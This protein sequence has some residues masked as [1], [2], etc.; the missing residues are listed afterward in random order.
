MAVSRN[1]KKV[2]MKS[3]K[4]KSYRG[5]KIS[6]TEVTGFISLS[7]VAIEDLQLPPPSSNIC[8][9]YVACDKLNIAP[10]CDVK[11]GSCDIPGTR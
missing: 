10:H 5:T 2:M 9:S 1:K 8:P 4:Q 7:F 11:M 3:R 6:P